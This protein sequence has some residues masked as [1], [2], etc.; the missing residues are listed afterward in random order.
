MDD[1]TFTLVSAAA[2]AG[3]ALGT[4]VGYRK[5][6]SERQNNRVEKERREVHEPTIG[7]NAVVQR[8]KLDVTLLY[9]NDFA[10]SVGYLGMHSLY[11]MIVY[12]WMPIYL[13]GGAVR[14]DMFGRFRK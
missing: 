2:A 10:R 13:L 1:I 7:Q 4:L 6:L 3:G 8:G 9:A 11:G 12:P 14:K 5:L